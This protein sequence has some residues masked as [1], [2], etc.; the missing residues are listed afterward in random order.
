MN[1][2]TKTLLT[3]CGV[4]VASSVITVGAFKAS[5]SGLSRQAD[6][7]LSD[8]GRTDANGRFLTVAQSAALETDFTAAAESTINGVVSIKSYV[9]LRQ[10][11]TRQ[12]TPFDDPF[13]E[14]F[15]GTPRRQ[16][17]QPQ[18]QEQQPKE[19]PMGLGSGVIISA[20]GH[21]VTNNHVIEGAERLEVTLNDNRTYDATVIGTDPTTDLALIKIEA[22]S[23]HVIPMGSSDNL[24]VGEWVLA[25]GNPFGFTSSVTSGIVSAKARNISS[26]TGAPGS[27]G[28]ESYIQTDAAVNS[29]NSG[30]ALVNLRGELVG[31][32]TAI[33]SQTGAYAGC[34]F[35]IPTS[36]VQ[37]VTA[38]LKQ[39]GTVQRAMLG[40]SF[41]E[42]SPE[43]IDEKKIKGVI[44]GIYVAEVSDL[45]AARE[46]GLREGDVITALNSYTTHSTA[47]LQEAITKFSPGDRVT[48]TFIRDGQKHSAEAVLRNAQGTTATVRE[49]NPDNL[50][51]TFKSLTRERLNELQISAGVEVS[52]VDSE[53]PFAEQGMRPGFIVLAIN[54]TRVS[55]PDEVKALARR[56]L[57]ADAGERVMFI[58]GFYPGGRRAFYAIDLNR[59]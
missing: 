23:L 40:I 6:T 43:L 21:I 49:I 22:D 50:G 36:I 14:F 39:Y 28:I 4:A 18:Q 52:S 5:D 47:Q 48:I 31:I 34:S 7:D 24:L 42:L 15:F 53:G 59:R 12:S 58:S 54:Q 10:R 51:A 3:A 26:A 27:G 45:S 2:F 17:Q 9:T 44:A 16:Q 25:V 32:N 38:D 56:I 20:D 33:Y 41:V 13:F 37:K 46:A 55:S 35:A 1:N 11:S 57:K 8:N 30:G 29:G 19:Q